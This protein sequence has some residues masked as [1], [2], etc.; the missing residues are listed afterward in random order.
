[1]TD[2]APALFVSSPGFAI[3]T[4]ADGALITP[5]KP[6]AGGEL[7]VIYAAGLGKTEASPAAGELLPYASP[8]LNR[9][10]FKLTL[11]AVATDP[12]RVLYCGI[13]PYSVGLYQINLTLPDALPANPE[14]VIFVGAA[15]SQAGLKLPLR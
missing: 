7:I 1:V 5:E 6:A 12:A 9:S 13:T 3:A 4:H 14:L 2:A 11:N 15:A 8:L 10:A